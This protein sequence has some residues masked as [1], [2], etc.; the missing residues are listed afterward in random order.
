MKKLLE[1]T[2]FSEIDHLDGCIRG[3]NSNE[4]F[5]VEREDYRLSFDFDNQM[6]AFATFDD[7][8]DSEYVL[9][10]KENDSNIFQ[11]VNSNIFY[12]YNQGEVFWFNGESF[13]EVDPKGSLL[14]LAENY[15]DIIDSYNSKRE[16]YYS[17]F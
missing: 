14:E 3:Y 11:E 6:I 15:E 1:H 13:E 8:D 12:K 2:R 9:L 17:N 7:M 16:D 5:G 4:S 10:A